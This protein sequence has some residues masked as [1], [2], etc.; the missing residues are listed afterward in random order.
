MKKIIYLIVTG[1]VIITMPSC[2]KNDTYAAPDQT[3]NGSVID[4]STGQPI[5]T[6][7]GTTNM[8]IRLFELSWNNGVGVI[9]EN[10][11][12]HY[13]GTFTN[14]KVFKGTYKIY[15]TDGPFVPLV[16]TDPVTGLLVDKGSKT[17]PID[18]GT[19]NV[20]FTVDP[21]LSV[22]WVG[23]PVVNADKTVTV[24]FK[25]TRGTT[26][27]TRQFDVT[28]AYLFVS[29]TPFVSFNSFDNL[30]STQVVYA[31]TAGTAL[32]GTTV[33]LTT[34]ALGADRQF[35]VRVGVRTADN[36]NKRYNYNAP[37]QVTIPK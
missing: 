17:I 1:M 13:D 25:F 22:A 32:L 24:Q 34:K 31:G 7:A 3:L 5:Q 4:S 36:V 33:T 19:T 28:D 37:V 6:E 2:I 18:G 29:T 10:F 8:Q 15:P 12:M 27:V 23:T 14:T 11:N 16:Y 20:S 9:P 21:F 26:D 35:F 30:T